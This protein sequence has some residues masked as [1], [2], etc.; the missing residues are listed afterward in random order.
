MLGL[1]DE[2]LG[3]SPGRDMPAEIPIGTDPWEAFKQEYAKESMSIPM[4]IVSY[5]VMV[6]FMLGFTKIGLNVVSGKP[7]GVGMLFGGGKWLMHGFIGY[8]LYSLMIIVG[9]ALFIFPGFYLMFRFGMYQ[10]AIVD[11]NLNAIEAFRY[12]S[13]ITANNK[14]NLFVLFLFAI[15]VMTA[16]CVALFVGI[17]F[18]YPVMWLMWIVA[19]RWM[20]YGG[21][22]VLDDPATGQPLLSAAPE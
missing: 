16:G 11:R 5:I 7:F 22:A 8:V 12:S 13:Q 18:A 1:A 19:Y 15:L 10:N 14:V 6:F 3:M 21:R 17:L 9:M 4:T 2:A 20:Q